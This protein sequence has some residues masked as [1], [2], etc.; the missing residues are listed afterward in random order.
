MH[1]HV[2]T[3]SISKICRKTV[4]ASPPHL[5]FVLTSVQML[6]KL[7]KDK[8]DFEAHK[9][10]ETNKLKSELEEEKRKIR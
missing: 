7:Q 10:K 5:V 2:A 6:S 4:I 3:I 8:D 9:E 1:W